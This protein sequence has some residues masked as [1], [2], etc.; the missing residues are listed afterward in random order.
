M[1]EW[2]IILMGGLGAALFAIGGTGYKWVRRY[3]MP[4]LFIPCLYLLGVS[5]ISSII[6][7]ALLALF[8]TLPYGIT[9]PWWGKALVGISYAV[10]SLVIGYSLWVYIVPIIFLGLF[11]L[12]SWQKTA[13]SF[14]WKVVELSYGFIIAMSLVQASLNKW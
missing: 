9:T 12:S 3:L 4:I 6:S 10:P 11:V 13:K 1:K 2:I 14:T 7:C 8:M 5:L